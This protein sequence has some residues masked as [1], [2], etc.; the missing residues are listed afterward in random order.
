MRS[1][2]MAALP[3][4]SSPS[5][6]KSKTSK[7][8]AGVLIGIHLLA[9]I[10]ITHWLVTGRS[11]TP[12]E[13]SEAMAFSMAGIINAGLIFFAVS[14]LLTLVFGR[15]FCGWACHLVA[16]QDLCRWWL[17]KL[18]IRPQPLRSRL[19]RWVP[20]LAFFYM[21]LWPAVYRL[22]IG[23]SFSR[24]EL[25]LTTDQ[26]WA[27]FPGWTIGILTFL[28]C[29]FVIV[30]LLGAKGFCTYACPYGAAFTLADRV[31]PMRIRVT[32]A[33]EGCAHCT[34]NCTSNVR[35]HA[36]VREYGM[37]VDDGCMKCLDCVSVCPNDALYYGPGASR[38]GALKSALQPRSR[39]ATPTWPEEF[40]LAVAFA[41]AFFTFRG[42]Y[43]YVPF[44]MSLGLAAVLAYMVLT[45]VRLV[46]RDNLS[47]RRWQLKR[48][49]RLL[50]AGYGFGALMA[51]LA[52]FW[53]HSGLVRSQQFLGERQFR[54]IAHLRFAAMDITHASR[55]LDQS[56]MSRVRRGRDH[57]EAAE[58]LGLWPTLGNHWRLA[59]M[60]YLAG[61][62]ADLAIEAPKAIEGDEFP[63]EMH[64]LLALEARHE[65]DTQGTLA[66]LE[67]VVEIDPASAQPH[68]NLG[69]VLAEAGRLEAAGVAFA[70]GLES[71]PRS[72]GLLYN[73]GLVH[74]Y[75]GDI[76]IAIALFEQTLVVAPKNL[77]ARENLA[78]MLASTGR[79]EE[80]IEHYRLA[81][82]QSPD[83]ADTHFLL[84]RAY[85]GLGDLEAAR[86][87][88]LECLSLEPGHREAIILRAR[89]DTQL[90]E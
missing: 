17:A 29:G 43:G 45:S 5:P 19:L 66:Q 89:I 13:P 18:G 39:A 15:L 54:A 78:G 21:F 37:V 47:L 52:I 23:D 60:Y 2:L 26:F 70:R 63:A 79:F 7:W 71:F 62:P 90:N 67:K 16:L 50:P 34:A 9:G 81:I 61:S 48:Q 58:R 57:L 69:L 56:E 20:F 30:Y 6:R 3:I 84:A 24:F 51:L 87:S 27:T 32:D 4:I 77:E 38:H 11:V 74:A 46:A 85:A 73:S 82:E 12:V 14:I 33:C 65:G 83:D 40:V 35:V 76:P 42:L 59:W 88:L 10:H 28:I 44:L 41:L 36:E 22:W 80:S 49:G 8:R 68:L 25:D 31:A 53:V 75:L 1:K 86:E 64:H 72:P 55:A